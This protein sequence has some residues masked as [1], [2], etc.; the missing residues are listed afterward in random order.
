[1]S[2]CSVSGAVRRE[3]GWGGEMGERTAA[4]GITVSRL[5]W[6]RMGSG[7]RSGIEWMLSMGGIGVVASGP[8]G[9]G[10]V[11]SSAILFVAIGADLEC[12]LVKLVW[13]E[14]AQKYSLWK[15]LARLG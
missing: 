10:S 6:G 4:S 9:V 11:G 15:L 13:L 8:S 7:G 3:G 1:M 5:G 12:S 14:E 2:D